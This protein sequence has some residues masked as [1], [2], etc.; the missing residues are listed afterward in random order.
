MKIKNLLILLISVLV[1]LSIT[2]FFGAYTFGALENRENLKEKFVNSMFN[3][4]VETETSI[5]NYLKFAGTHYSNISKDLTVYSNWEERTVLDP[6]DGTYTL[7]NKLTVSPYVVANNSPEK[8]HVAYM[9]FFSNMNLNNV[10]PSKL[11]FISVQGTSDESYAHLGEAIEQFDTY[12]KEDQLTG[13]AA[14]AAIRGGKTPIFDIHGVKVSSD[15]STSTPLAYSITPTQNYEVA[16]ENGQEDHRITFTDLV[17]CSWAIIEVKSDTKT[18]V[19]MSGLLENIKRNPDAL[20]K[21]NDV[22]EGYGLL[23]TVENKKGE[24]IL[25]MDPLMNAGY[26]KFALP[27]L[28]LVCGISLVITGF[29]GV[30]FFI[31][32][33]YEEEDPKKKLKK[34]K[35]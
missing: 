9:F 5:E 25:D 31:T 11:Y 16:D 18:E 1:P 19:L 34:S 4:K 17:S 33:T 10:S 2:T 23:T 12:W 6:V 20:I 29:L 24:Q 15:D 3:E 7:N 30:V 28:A 35:K 32:W 14:P 21:T 27:N 26:F 8:S 22:K 13:S